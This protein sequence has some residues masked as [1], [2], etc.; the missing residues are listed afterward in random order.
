[1]SRL[2][3]LPAWL[4]TFFLAAVGAGSLVFAA[5]WVEDVSREEQWKK[6]QDAINKGLPQTAIRELNPIIDSAMKDKA[7]AEASKALTRKLVL[8]GTIQGNQPDEKV[9]RLKAEIAKAPAEIRPVLDAILGHW[10]WHYFQQSRWRFMQR[11]Q[12]ASS[13]GDDFTTWDLPRIFAEIDKQFTAALAKDEILKKTKIAEYDA[14]IEKGDLPDAYRPTLWDFIVWEAMAFYQAGEQAGAKM[15]D[16]FEFDAASPVFGSTAEFLKW[17]PETPD[18]NAPKLKAIQLYQKLLAFHGKSPDQSAFLDADLSRLKFGQNFAFG[19]EKTA[20]YKAA[21]KKFIDDNAD[22]EMSAYAR[23]LLAETINNEGDHVA[24]KAI[25]KQGMNAFP[26]SRG[27][28]SCQNLILQIEAKSVTFNSERVWNA[29]WPVVRVSYQN[30]DKVYLRAYAVDWEKRLSGNPRRWRPEQYEQQADQALL[31]EKP[32]ASWSADLTP[33]PDHKARHEDIAVP[34]DIKPGFYFIYASAD[35]NFEMNDNSGPLAACPVWVSDLALIFRQNTGSGKLEGFVLKNQS[36]DPVN[37]A[38]I[39][40]WKRDNRNNQFVVGPVGKTDANGRFAIAIDQNTS[41]A[42]MAEFNGQKLASETDHY[43]YR[44]LGNRI[45]QQGQV[46]FFT[47]RAIYRPGQSVKFKGIAMRIDQEKDN[48]STVANQKLNVIFSDVN[49]KEIAKLDVKTNEFG[50][51]S[52]SFTAPRDRL[53]GMMTIRVQDGTFNGATQV[54]VEEYKRPQFEVKVESPKEVVKLN[55]AV[56]LTGK[57]TAYTGSAVNGAKVSYRVTR[58]VRFPDWWY[59]FYYWRMPANRGSAQEIAHG[60]AVTDADGAFKVTFT[61]KPDLSVAE[62]D[63][64]KFTYRV[65]ADVTDTTGETRSGEKS[66]TVGYTALEASVNVDEWLTSEKPITLKVS[67]TTPNGDP[68]GAK[69][70]IKIHALKQPASVIRSS[71]FGGRPTP[72]PIRGRGAAVLPKPNPEGEVDPADPRGW[73]L[74]EQIHK[75]DFATKDDGKQELT[76]KLE[77][78]IYRAV[79]ETQDAFGK[80][81]GSKVQLLVVKPDAKTFSVKVAN[82]VASESWK[83]EPGDEF[84]CIWGTG[85]DRSRAFVEVI[86]RGKVLQAFWTDPERTQV[87]VK[88]AVTEAMRGGFTVMINQVR[89]NR[90]YFT[91]H[92]VDVPWTNKDLSV[93]WE[94][95]TS[96]LEPS[97][98]ETWTAVVTG[99]KAM[100]VT[101]EF[102][103]G[104]YDASL[105]AFAKHSWLH[106]FNV[107]R[108]DYMYGSYSFENH[109]AYFNQLG[110]Y[111]QQTYAGVPNTYRHFPADITNAYFGFMFPDGGGMGGFGGGRPTMMR[112]GA[113]GMPGAPAPMSAATGR[114][115]GGSKNGALGMEKSEALMAKDMAVASPAGPGGEP[116]APAGAPSVNLAGVSPRK[117]L[118]ETAFFLPHLVTEENGTVRISFQMPEAVTKWKFFGFAHD[119]ELRS[120]YLEGDVVTAKDLMVR[121]NP[122]RFLREGDQIEFTVKVNNQSPTLQKGLVKLLL[123]DARTDKPIDAAFGIAG[124]KSFEIVSKGS[125]TFSWK[126]TVPDGQGPVVY[127]AVAGTERTSDGEEGMMPVLSKRILVQESLPL[128]IRGAQTK[129]FEF[130]KLLESGKSDTIRNQSLTVQMVSQPAW[131]AVLALPYLMEYPHECSEQTFNRLYANMLARHIAQK[132]PKIRRVF[133]IWKESQPDALKSPLFKNQD[134]KAVMIEETPWLRA[135]DKESEARKNVGILFDDNRLNDESAR[136]MAKLA[137]MQNNDGLWPW[138]PGGRSNE[139]ISLYIATGF[140][141]MRHLG[142]KVD[143]APAVKAWDALDA[144][145][146]RWYQQIKPEHR[147]QN[148]LSTTVAFYLYGRSFFMEDK[149]VAQQFTTAFN[150]WKGQAAKYWLK[151]ANR[152]SQGHI[153]LALKRLA[154]RDTPTAIMNSLRE[155]S[156][157][158]EEMGMFWRDTEQQ[159][160]WY[161]AP[162]ET[163]A[164]MIEAFE[165]V[166]NDAKAVEDCKVWLLKQKQTQNWKTTKA[167]ADAVYSLLLRGDNLLTSDAL[168]EVKVG[169][170]PI[171]PENV[172]AGTGFYEEKFVRKEIKPEMGKITVK[173]TDPGVSWGSV[174]WQYL[175]D[176]SKVTPHTDTP[177]TLEKKLYK[178][179]NTNKGKTL[180]EVKGAIEVGDELVC[181]VVLRSDRDLEYV[182]L[183]DHRGSGTEPVNV[184]SQYK[185]QD[186]LMYYESTKDTASHFFIDYLPKGTYVFEYSVRVQLRGKYTTG[187]ANI[188]CMYAPEFSSHSQSIPL[189]VK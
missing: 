36:G 172:E 60:I 151:L 142:V 81:V 13:P 116:G 158:N 156:V 134:L 188:Q 59:G 168:V 54:R 150:Y 169:D 128:P 27:G 124:E 17:K 176:I 1:M 152:Q 155:R 110:G 32:A 86:H 139:F 12:T 175:E 100:K 53:T 75:L 20:R 186:G 141:R 113:A 184:L 157:S 131:Y 82:H 74:G 43:V 114:F 93:K 183:K 112:G 35:A 49:G 42:A 130:K 178:K 106:K 171:K 125:Q 87:Q 52:G 97:Q 91:T 88:Q 165:E 14:L 140:G 26:K 111:W 77:P 127:T 66:V 18:T 15:Q 47:D 78:G 7:Y 21:L 121:P 174:H 107:F 94:R 187:M 38:T 147:D 62:K 39:R 50:S 44:N 144:M 143:V 137:D 167:T 163:Q 4:F 51:F 135:A 153:A 56:T 3:I 149:P 29:P 31:K 136:G 25:A 48:Y 161:R 101:A 108:Q 148:H 71:Y 30:I 2:R 65:V 154:D 146:D 22:H 118:N 41:W 103:A 10:Y 61:A 73:D 83:A 67:T 23:Y 46:A 92:H 129:T 72:R 64:P 16:A 6:V 70:T 96:K 181:R 170:N 19:E 123:K 132:D 164:I 80:P 90:A 160:W 109:L 117:N 177:L 76:T 162:I 34:K 84:Q 28:L 40:T 179:V 185:F 180:E 166:A 63:E 5:T 95:F 120:G 122:P 85:Y 126:L 159:W 58:E 55:G 99:P 133:D 138:F 119:K 37:G 69:G 79:L 89:E 11:T 182:H 104:L 173:K 102:V 9:K 189:E 115:E 45:P 24:A 105:D 98:K 57:A 33:T 145:M 8:E 68:A